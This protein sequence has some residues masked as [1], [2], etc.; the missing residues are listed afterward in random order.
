MMGGR[1]NII[2]LEAAVWVGSRVT[3]NPEV[4]PHAWFVVPVQT[5][6]ATPF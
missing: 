3:A 2:C 5:V 6:D 1:P 4:I